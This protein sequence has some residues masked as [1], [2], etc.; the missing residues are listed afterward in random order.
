VADNELTVVNATGA[1]KTLR[2]VD[3]AGLHHQVVF[4][5]EGG[6]VVVSPTG[7][8]VRY[9][10]LNTGSVALDPPNAAA[11]YARLRVY[12]TNGPAGATRRLYYRTDGTA[13]QN[14]GAN[15]FGYLLHGEML[16][17][18]I[19]DFTLFSMIADQA[20][21]G[22]FQVYVEWLNQA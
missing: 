21:G 1:T 22:A 17:V 19:A 18:R 5:H 15:A 2:D 7:G 9:T 8:Q 14:N 4:I 16:L 6:E 3:V 12:E 20:D 10:V 11:R 13:P